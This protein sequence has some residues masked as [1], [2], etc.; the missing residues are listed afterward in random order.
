M[1]WK[2]VL[3][4]ACCL[5]RDVLSTE[6]GWENEE[7]HSYVRRLTSYKIYLLLL[8]TKQKEKA[9]RIYLHHDSNVCSPHVVL[10]LVSKK[11]RHVPNRVSYTQ[12]SV[13]TDIY[14]WQ[15]YSQQ[16]KS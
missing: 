14:E 9:Q 2:Y 15:T 7:G 16:P 4:S 10:L 8:H 12:P 13:H 5:S 1:G 3:K 6:S 11:W